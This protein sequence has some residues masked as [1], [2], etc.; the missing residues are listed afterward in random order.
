M[1][2]S[3]S[4][5]LQGS[6]SC[7]RTA[8]EEQ[9]SL[10]RTSRSSVAVLHCRRIQLTSK[11]TPST[12]FLLSRS[13]S[14]LNCRSRISMRESTRAYTVRKWKQRGRHQ[15]LDNWPKRIMMHEYVYRDNTVL[16]VWIVFTYT[17]IKRTVLFY[18]IYYVSHFIYFNVI[19]IENTLNI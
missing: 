9:L 11:Q 8:R 15:S 16:M 7:L 2:L 5:R 4:L 6:G 13:E 12:I 19:R 10:T 17:H 1:S 14:G 3:T 18:Y